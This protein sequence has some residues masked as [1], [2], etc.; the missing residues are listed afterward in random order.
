MA[1]VGVAVEPPALLSAPAES[2]VY[3][4]SGRESVN[5]T[6]MPSLTPTLSPTPVPTP[7]PTP[8]VSGTPIPGMVIPGEAE[9]QAQAQ[10]PPDA[11]SGSGSGSTTALADS[12]GGF[13]RTC[14][15]CKI[16]NRFVPEDLLH[17][18][19]QFACFRDIRPGAPHHYLVVPRR[20][21]GNC[22]T[23]KKEHISIVQTMVAIG[24]NVLLQKGIAD[25]ADVRLGFHWPPFCTVAHLHLHVLAPVSQMGFL[26]RMIYRANS[27]WF[28]THEHLIE[29]LKALP[30]DGSGS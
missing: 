21:I 18:D 6:P 25:P 2:D 3:D 22:K 28:I 27:Y 4:G 10:A 8:A 9:A 26:S 5:A 12:A 30:D 13:D 1:A 14:V 24:K 20:H 16:S 23:L 11:G 29:K 19:E 17:W 7:A 15:F